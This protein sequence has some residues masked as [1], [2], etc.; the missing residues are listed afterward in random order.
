MMGTKRYETAYENRPE[1]IRHREER[2]KARRALIKKDGKAAL[3]GKDAG[4]KTPLTKGGSNAPSNTFPQSV[5]SNRGWRRH[6]RGYS[7]P[8]A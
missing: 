2:N 5:K 8:E 4:H 6:G 3:A 1:Q 7:V